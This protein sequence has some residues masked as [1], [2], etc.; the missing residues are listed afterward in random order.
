MT[1]VA[2][3][4][5]LGLALAGWAALAWLVTRTYPDNPRVLAQFYAALFVALSTTVG[6]LVW[7]TRRAFTPARAP[8]LPLADLSH[9][10]ALSALVIFGLWLQSLRLL[11][12]LHVILLVG[13]FL[14]F[15]LVVAIGGRNV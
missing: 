15:E 3:V 5:Q 8:R 11:S 1:I 9:G 6:A 7:A 14:F 10:M 12:P 2:L 13:L 4:L